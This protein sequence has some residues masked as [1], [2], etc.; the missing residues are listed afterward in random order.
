MEIIKISG[1]SIIP[2]DQLI[3]FIYY[4]REN[5]TVLKLKNGDIIHF[6]GDQTKEM[7]FITING[8]E[9]TETYV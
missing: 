9:T 4:P 1:D 3:S 6:D 7:V 2:F 5:K 8:S